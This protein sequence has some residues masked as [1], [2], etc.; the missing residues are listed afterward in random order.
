MIRIRAIRNLFNLS[1]DEAEEYERQVICEIDEDV[2]ECAEM[3]TPAYTGVPAPAYLED[4]EWFNEP[5]LSDKQEEIK[6][7]F[8]AA[9][10]E[11]LEDE[12]IHQIMYDLST[13]NSP[14]LGGSENRF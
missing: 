5:V 4:D 6:Q 11:A 2:V 8:Y 7:D 9:K 13:K 12:S 1:Q 3:N 10:Q 14:E